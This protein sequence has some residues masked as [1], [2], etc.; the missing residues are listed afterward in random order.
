V[1][2]EW[3]DPVDVVV[4]ERKRGAEYYLLFFVTQEQEAKKQSRAN[5]K[6]QKQHESPPS[7]R[8]A[9]TVRSTKR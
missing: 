2:V 3:I 9:M 1:L 6:T 5:S 8:S 4:S 7:F